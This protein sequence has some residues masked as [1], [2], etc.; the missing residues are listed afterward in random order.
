MIDTNLTKLLSELLPLPLARLTLFVPLLRARY[1][2]NYNQANIAIIT[3]SQARELKCNTQH[4]HN[5]SIYLSQD[6][7]I[8]WV[9]GALLLSTPLGM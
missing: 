3:T 7:Q 8:H 5:A 9:P 1:K 4:R 2:L 6:F